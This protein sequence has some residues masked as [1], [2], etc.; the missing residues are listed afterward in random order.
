MTLALQIHVER[1]LQLDVSN[2]PDTVI[3]QL[4]V[5][6]SGLVEGFVGRPME[7]ASYDED[8]TSPAGSIVVL[9]NGPVDTSTNAVVVTLNATATVL[10]LNTDYVVKPALGHIVRVTAAGVPQRWEARAG[11]QRAI[12]VTY[13][14][15]YDF[16]PEDVLAHRYA[17]VAR[18]VT[19]RSVGR[20]FQAAA[21]A[22]SIPVAALAIKSLSLAGSDSVT[23]RDGIGL[24]ADAAIQLT[25]ADKASLRVVRRKVFV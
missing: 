7:L 3:T 10:V 6:A 19:I 9:R 8:H 14:A 25:D 13:D 20:V 5:T 16:A 18:D 11:L 4:L 24:V 21:A 15:G 17:E 23:Y 1:F 22:A 2:E 12:N